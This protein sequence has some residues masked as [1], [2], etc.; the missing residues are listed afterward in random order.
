MTQSTSTTSTDAICEAR[1]IGVVF[2]G[3]PAIE[4]VSLSVNPNEV[5]AILGPSG[6]GKS[7]LLRVLVGLIQ[8]TTGQVFA[9]GQTLSGI[10]S[11]ISIVFQ[12]FALYPWLT[13]RENIQVALNG[14]NLDPQTASQRVARCIDMVGLDGSE[15][16]YPKEL[17]GGMKQRVGIARALARGPELLCMDEPFSALDVFT[18][19]SLRSEV[20]R[21]WTVNETKAPINGNGAPAAHGGTGLR[22]IM[23]ITHI[24]EEAVFLADRIVVMGTKPGHIRQII[25]NTV[26]HPRNYQSPQFLALVQRLHDII[27][28]EHLPE[29]PAAAASVVATDILAVEPVPSV[30]LGEVFGLM[31]ILRD[32]G[33]GMDVFRLDGLT[34]YDFGHTLSVVKT[35]EMLDFLD[36]PKNRVVLTALG[37]KFLDADINGRKGLLNQQL[38]T[39]GI[40]RYIVTILKEAKNQRLPEE[41]VQEEL[42]IRLPTEDVD[43]MTRT[44]IAWGRFAELLGYSADTEEIYLDQPVALPT[45]DAPS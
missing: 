44:I 12:N 7:T 33:G 11:G 13:V 38:Q 5:I 24:I 41:V 35:G 20:Y 10:H 37:A 32:N 14:L 40:F 43:A 29:E 23:M 17:S 18:A 26:A 21:L 3:R 34:D 1:N 31:E 39:L 15:E 6:C 2:N 9:H 45:G 4:N 30:N 22:S 8:P 25:P 28:S 42:V 36:T 19:E 16:A 27:V